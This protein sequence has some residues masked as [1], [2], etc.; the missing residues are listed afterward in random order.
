MIK[1]YVAKVP[2]NEDVLMG[3]SRQD[4]ATG[5]L[6]GGEHLIHGDSIA[7][8]RVMAF[9]RRWERFRY[10]T[11]EIDELVNSQIGDTLEKYG[12]EK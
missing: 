9:T 2:N 1:Q 4:A 8:E 11:T 6:T 3:P 5:F 7:E 10:W 12:Y